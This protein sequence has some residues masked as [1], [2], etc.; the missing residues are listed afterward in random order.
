MSRL[1]E[2]APWNSGETVTS[3]ISRLAKAGGYASARSYAK[4]M[5]FSFESVV[6]G[7]L[8]DAARHA[9]VL[10]RPLAL[11]SD[12]LV[13]QKRRIVLLRGEKLILRQTM[14]NRLRFCPL[15]VEADEATGRGRRGCRAYGR[16]EWQ[17][18][19]VRACPIHAVRL[20]APDMPEPGVAEY[21]FAALLAADTVGRAGILTEHDALEPDS[22]QDYVWS[23]LDDGAQERGW[24]ADMPLYDVIMLTEIV[25]AIVRHG[26]FCDPDTLKWK[27]RSLCAEAGFDIVRQGEQTFRDFVFSLL[28]RA[29]PESAHL[30][31]FLGALNQYL[32]FAVEDY[33]GIVRGIIREVMKKEVEQKVR[34]KHHA[35]VLSIA[36][37]HDVSPVKLRNRLVE[38]GVVEA[39][40]VITPAT[41]VEV[42]RHLG[43]LY[44]SELSTT[45]SYLEAS[46][47]LGT[48]ASV[49]HSNGGSPDLGRHLSEVFGIDG[50]RR[51]LISEVEE[52][53][54]SF[55][56][57]AG[58]EDSIPGMVTF[59]GVVGKLGFKAGEVLKLLFNGKLKSVALRPNSGPGLKA[60]RFDLAE[61]RR[62]AIAENRTKL[63]KPVA[64][65]MLKVNETTLDLILRDGYLKASAR[66]TSVADEP[67]FLLEEIEEF[68][69]Q[70]IAL[71]ELAASR[72][73]NRFELRKHLADADVHPAFEANQILFYR[74]IDIH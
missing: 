47:S 16:L 11:F 61:V 48:D 12:G 6:A 35:T 26:T 5:G 57:L 63:S 50:R 46:R 37:Q 39:E 33:D 55:Q 10:D 9:E 42:D 15:C 66:P 70:F 68:G 34:P 22:L 59:E 27:E 52:L 64:A 31:Q 2:L 65:K 7:H 30:R 58:T 21:D 14:R 67:I 20:E 29:F 24:L 19:A 3:H 43:S 38:A 44:C 28:E 62:E 23:R 60:L 72:M 73:T 1:L 32:S 71:H 8:D 13:V 36:E 51:Y 49:F 45:L 56:E 18:L 4:A 54:K 74:V 40:L 25:G 41:S 53:S 69:R 17:V